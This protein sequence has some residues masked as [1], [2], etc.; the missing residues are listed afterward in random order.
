M[1][2]IY[3][4][5]KKI[6]IEKSPIVLNYRGEQNWQDY[7][8]VMAGNWTYDNGFL[9]GTE[10]E[11]KGGILYT[12]E[13]YDFDIMLTFKC[14]T[15]LPATRDLNALWCSNWDNSADY[16]S[17]GYVCGLNGWYDHLSGIEKCGEH[18]FY[19]ST[20]LYKYVPGT[21]VEITCGSINGHCF[22]LVDGKLVLEIVDD[23]P[24]TSGHAGFS[25]YCTS[26][27]IRDVTIR[28]I[29]WEKRLQSYEKEF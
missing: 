4:L 25:P 20:S 2:D 13:C 24:L 21:E 27:K 7:F 9:I 17:D 12:K 19:A 16:L 5:G 28:K 14:Q 3:L 22:L 6:I 29:C 15:V 23:F 26:L 18:G 1:Q 11:N 10:I 8:M